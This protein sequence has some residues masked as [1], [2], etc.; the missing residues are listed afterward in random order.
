MSKGPWTRLTKDFHEAARE[1]HGIHARKKIDLEKQGF[2]ARA[3]AA[4][5]LHKK[6][7]EIAD[8]PSDEWVQISLNVE[9]R[10]VD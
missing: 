10:T 5:L 9:K 8:G 3:D 7:V 6:A 4:A 1:L 2:M